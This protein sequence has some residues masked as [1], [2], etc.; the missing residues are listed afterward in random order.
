MPLIG[1]RIGN[2]SRRISAESSGLPENRLGLAIK[3]L[4]GV[5]EIGSSI[6][7]V[8]FG[9]FIFF[10]YTSVLGLPGSLVAAAQVVGLV[11]N[12]IVDPYI[13]HLS[14]RTVF[15]L[16]RR[17]GFM[18]VGAATSGLSFWLLFSPP[19]GLSTWLLFGWLL[20]TSL[21]VRFVSSL[22]AIPYHALGAELTSDVAE[23][24]SVSGIRG[25]CGLIGL[26]LSAALVFRVFFPNVAVG[27]DPKLDNLRYPVMGLTFGIIMSGIQLVSIISTLGLRHRLV[28]VK[29]PNSGMREFV[30]GLAL[31]LKGPAFRSLVAA[32]TLLFLGL[33]VNSLLF[34]HFLT[35]YVQVSDSNQLSLVQVAFY[36]SATLAVPVWLRVLKWVE[37]RWLFFGATMSTAL[38]MVAARVL[39]GPG[40]TFGTGDVRPLI[41]G[42]A[43]AGFFASLYFILPASMMADVADADELLSGRRREGTLF[44]MSSFAEQ[45]A[46]GVAVLAVGFLLDNFAGLVPGQ[47]LQA[48]LTIERI[49]IMYG[50]VPAV[51]LFFAGVAIL[52]YP[53]DRHSLIE[54]QTRQSSRTFVNAAIDVPAEA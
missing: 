19:P 5:G 4:Y 13:G 36:G 42:E 38:I 44:G 39:V 43:I 33:A 27:V 7:L 6:R 41:V 52:F 17:H 21:A 28:M 10:F 14:D 25:A 9:L 15:W 24:N 23:R 47:A 53:L 1:A 11:W 50:V 2:D 46:G 51:A 16:G 26:L 8:V 29:V 3:V 49:G 31:S 22:F 48:S 20:M 40:H 35:F 34:V 12:A 37:K 45:V 32:T 54:I 18:I 30:D